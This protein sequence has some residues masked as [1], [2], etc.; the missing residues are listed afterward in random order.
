MAKQTITK[1][2]DDIDGSAADETVKFAL[3]TDLL[4]IDL[5]D[6]NAKKLRTLLA[7]YVE[8]G[9][10]A[11]SSLRRP[12]RR[13]TGPSPA[14]LKALNAKIRDWAIAR[15]IT[16]HPRGRIKERIVKAY[17]DD[18]A[19]RKWAL[20]P[21]MYDVKAEDVYAAANGSPGAKQAAKKVPGPKFQAA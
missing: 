10:R 3:D 11:D 18:M 14:D 15:H 19:G 20:P 2:I 7:P 21:E 5:S 9:R 12:T 1:L 8:K 13:V 6:K 4:E 17:H 16:V